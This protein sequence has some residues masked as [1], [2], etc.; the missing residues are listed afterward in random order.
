MALAAGLAAWFGA[1]FKMKGENFATKRDFDELLKRQQATTEAV[2]KI[3]SDVAQRDWSQREW[4]NLRR[5]KL[6]E[7][8]QKM[9]DSEAFLN[10]QRRKAIDGEIEAQE[11]DKWSELEHNWRSLFPGT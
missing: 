9:H 2:E 4:T 3:K 1:F 5:I 11:R 6:D 7:L 8:L 10:V